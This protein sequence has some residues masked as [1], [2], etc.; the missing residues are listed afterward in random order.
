MAAAVESAAVTTVMSVAVKGAADAEDRKPAAVKQI[1]W[2]EDGGAIHFN[3]D[4][5]KLMAAVIELVRSK[6]GY[7]EV[8]RAWPAMKVSWLCAVIPAVKKVPAL[9]SLA[10]H[11]EERVGNRKAA[12]EAAVSDGKIE[13]ED[14]PLYLEEQ[15]VV[16]TVEG[17]R[18]A[19]C[20]K[21]VALV[22][23]WM[24]TF[25]RVEIEV[26]HVLGGKLSLGMAKV[27]VREFE[28]L[29]DLKDLGVRLLDEKTKVALEERGMRLAGLCKGGA[30]YMNYAG[31]VV[32][33][34][35]WSE[36]RYRGDGRVIVDAATMKNQENDL[37]RQC[38]Q[39]VGVSEDR[40][41]DDDKVVIEELGAGEGWRLLPVAVGFS[42]RVKKWGLICMDGLSEVKWREDAFDKLVLPAEEKEL[43][44]SVV[45]GSSGAFEDIVEGKGG[46]F[47]FLLHGPP[48]QGKT[49]TAETVAEALKR[50]LY[51]VTVGELGVSPDHLE[52]RL[53]DILDIATTWDAVLLLDEADIFLEARNEQ[54]V[55]RNAMVGVFLRLLEYHQGVLFLTTNRVRNIDQAFFS[56]ISVPLKFGESGVSKRHQIWENLLAAAGV[57]GLD[58][59]R[60][61]GH[62]MNGRQIKNTIRLAQTLS[63]ARKVEIDEALIGEVVGL[64][65]GF[66][67]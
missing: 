65:T 8:I 18:A 39:Y 47:I 28:G 61:A 3:S 59:E 34:G 9:A 48:G 46:G 62:D 12:M 42:F 6:F 1:R 67:V 54:D 14:V 21:S 66:K 4:D 5:G 25:W 40:N 63:A 57:E 19:G 43:V 50:P 16:F 53:R 37:L 55:L 41:D 2:R 26:L 31:Q 17:Q 58:V 35:W 13:F 23:T 32:Q 11:L 51:S 20:V 38:L 60:L 15:E 29:K 27:N 33:P 56:R 7:H 52:E 49:L 44:R 22:Q 64:T 36:R 45:E 24:S 30:S 10:A